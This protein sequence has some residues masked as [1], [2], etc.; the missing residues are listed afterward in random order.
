MTA[1]VDFPE[2]L[3]PVIQT[4]TPFCPSSRCRSSR[5]TEPSCQV[6]FVAFCSA[7]L[8]LLEERRAQVTLAEAAHDGDDHLSLILRAGRDLCGGGDVTAGADAAEDALFLCQPTSPFERLFV[9]DLDDLVDD[10]HV[11]VFRHEAG[12]DSLDP[13][14][15]RFQLLALH[16]LRNHRRGYR[17]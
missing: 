9:G 8:F 15:A 10:L 14:A 4:V 1:I 2:A 13:V 5:V 17:L 16:L 11:E 3:R 6:T 12:P 7:N